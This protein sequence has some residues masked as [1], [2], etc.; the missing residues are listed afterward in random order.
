MVHLHSSPDSLPDTLECLLPLSFTTIPFE[1]DCTRW[2]EA[3]TC[4]PAP[5]GHPPSNVQ[6]QRI[7]LAFFVRVTLQF[8][9][10]LQDLRSLLLYFENLLL[11]TLLTMRHRL[12]P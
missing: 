5:A 10:F 4:I 2:F 8:S 12:L 11:V 7:C 6:H 1:Y 9:N 3:C